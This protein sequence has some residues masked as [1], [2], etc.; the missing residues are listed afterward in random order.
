MLDV[1]CWLAVFLCGVFLV[2]F[3]GKCPGC[4]KRTKTT[5][6]W[7]EE[8]QNITCLACGHVELMTWE[9]FH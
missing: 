6:A 9:D 3:V 5:R 8:G 4:K 2:V 7:C 1:I